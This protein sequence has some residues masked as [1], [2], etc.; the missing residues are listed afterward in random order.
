VTIV[1]FADYECKH[2]KEAQPLMQQL[3]SK[4]ASDITLYFKHFPISSNNAL[5]AAHAAAAAQNQG[6][7][8]QFSDKVWE[9]SEHL[10]PAVLESLAKEIGLDFSRWYGDVG[11]E[12]VR[13]A[14]A[15]GQD[16]GT[17]PGDPQN[18]R[19][20]HQR[21]SGTPTRSTFPV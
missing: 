15:T 19:H 16:R 3:L 13:G 10:S 7:F 12:E 14:R 1:E 18:A 5:N 21:P 2:C 20:F 6:K 8:W 4:Y 9:N 11:S 17:Q